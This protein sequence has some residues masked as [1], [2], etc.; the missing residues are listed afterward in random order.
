MTSQRVKLCLFVL[1]IATMGL[2]HAES[3]DAKSK[4]QFNKVDTWAEGVVREVNPDKGTFTLNGQKLPFASAHA[5][6]RKE[7]ETKAAGASLEKR[8][9]FAEEINREWRNKLMAAQSEKPGAA[10]ELKLTSPKDGDLVLLEKKS[11]QD[12]TFAYQPEEAGQKTEP[13]LMGELVSIDIYDI[14]SH[15]DATPTAASSLRQLKPGD[16]VKI[17]FDSATK[18]AYLM[19]VLHGAGAEAR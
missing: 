12:V 11:V 15:E 13:N 5:A 10:T 6:M 3:T 8:Q 7:F 17:G 1:S 9:Q 19:I 4:A 16:L 18:E 2:L 14:P